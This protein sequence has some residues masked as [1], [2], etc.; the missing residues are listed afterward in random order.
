ML[1]TAR[2]RYLLTRVE[3][4]L[5][6]VIASQREAMKLGGYRP[7]RAG[8]AFGE[9]S[10]LPPLRLTT[11]GGAKVQVRGK[12]DR[13]DAL[14]GAGDAA[15]FDYR[16]SVEPLSIQ[17]V[18]HG[19]SLQLLTYL[20]LLQGAGEELAGRPLTPTAAFYLQLLRSFG[21]VKHPDEALDP[22]D[23]RYLLAHKPRGVFHARA[24]PDLDSGCGEGFSMAVAAYIK[25]D[26]TFGAIADQIISG[27]I[28]VAPY[29]LNRVSPC[30][31]CE[32][33]GVC[34]FETSVNSYHH[35]ASMDRGQVLEKLGQEARDEK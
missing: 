10:L 2:N 30:P 7:I 34:R 1:S 29:R 13:V 33:R 6:Q 19:L 12:I 4:T 20:L 5:D 24:L 16:L 26:G 15:V 28:D 17:R 22:S 3:Q 18:Y 14:P 11:P 35:L 31:G 8:V 27:K 21:D 23:P 32:Y 9:G 25:K